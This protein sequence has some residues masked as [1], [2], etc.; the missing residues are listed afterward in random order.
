METG[1][2]IP[3]QQEFKIKKAGCGCGD[4]NN[5]IRGRVAAD[6]P[7]PA[8]AQGKETHHPQDSNRSRKKKSFFKRVKDFFN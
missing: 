4:K 5:A 7:A 8:A 1:S 2:K 3:Q 6:V